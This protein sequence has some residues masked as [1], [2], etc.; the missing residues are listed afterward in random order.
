MIFH[1]KQAGSTLLGLIIGLIIGL[2]I[3]VIVAMVMTKTSMPFLNKASRPD[4]IMDTPASQIADPNQPLYGNKPATKDANKAPPATPLTEEDKATADKP[5]PGEIDKPAPQPADA[6]APDAKNA[7]K[8]ATTKSD[9]T[10]DKFTYYLQAG[11]FREQADAENIKAKLA[12]QG[13]EADI[14]ER[15]SDNGSLYRVRLG[16]FNQLEA[17]DRVRS[18]LTESGIDVAV[19]RV[20]K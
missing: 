16:P 1:R 9:N 8:A 12:L 2:G 17:V 15:I 11:A 20:A 5:K 7:P 6:K 14:S 4:K 18:K 3:A 19:V 13:F 10:D